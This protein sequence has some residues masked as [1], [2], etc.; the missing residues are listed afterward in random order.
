M[1]RL[2]VALAVLGSTLT[3]M[4]APTQVAAQ[5]CNYSFG[6]VV[7]LTGTPHLFIADEQGILHWGG[8]TRGLAN[9]LVDWNNRCNVG[10]DTLQG[11]RRGDPW[12]SSGLPK[13]GDPIYLSKWETEEQAPRLLHIQTIADVELFGINTANYGNFILEQQ[14]WEQR[15]GFA[16]GTVRVGPLAS[17]ASFA[18]SPA[19]QASYRQLL[20]NMENV[21]STA[22]FRANQAGQNIRPVLSQVADCERDGLNDFGRNRNSAAALSITETCI[23]RIFP[24]GR[25]PNQPTNVRLTVITSTQLRLTWDEVP[26]ATGYRIYGGEQPTSQTTVFNSTAANVTSYD[27]AMR[28]PGTRYCFSVA[29]LNAA[30]ESIATGPACST[31]AS[32]PS[33]PVNLRLSEAGNGIRLDWTPTSTIQ[34]GFRI[35]RSDQQVASVGPDIT[36][37]VDFGWDPRVLNCYRVVAFN[38][39]GE[40]S[41]GSVCPGTGTAPSAPTNLRLTPLLG[42]SGVRLD[43]TNTATN[44]DSIR[45]LHRSQLIATLGHDATMYVDAT[46]APGVGPDC[47]QVVAVNSQGQ[48]ASSQACR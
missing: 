40:A 5:Q 18:W 30:G 8:D 9:R 14:V 41:T 10:L 15:Y 39:S 32:P 22:L 7:Q 12:L 19:D 38:S 13:I 31:I 47:Y 45:I 1:F 33:A 46:P 16:A 20:A 23:D 2:A 35:L 4:L 36:T 27:I 42:G 48:A 17:A 44:A 26:G 24:S 3:S 34:D 6:N 37:Y 28:A 11:A 43:W 29:A 21:E 25:V